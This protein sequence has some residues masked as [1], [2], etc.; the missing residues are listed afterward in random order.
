VLGHH[1]EQVA[2]QGALVRVEILGQRVDRNLGALL[3]IAGADAQV[4]AP[5]LG[6]LGGLAV[7]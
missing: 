1:R 7:V 6:R 5:V 3:G 2:E 4:P